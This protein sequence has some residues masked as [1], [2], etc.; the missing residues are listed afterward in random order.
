MHVALAPSRSSG[1]TRRRRPQR[2]NRAERG[3]PKEARE[4]VGADSA[5]A[6]EPASKD[7]NE[8]TGDE[9]RDLGA[10]RLG[11]AESRELGAHESRDHV[12]KSPEDLL[13]TLP[14]C[15]GE[16]ERMIRLGMREERLG[17][18][19]RLRGLS[20]RRV[21]RFQRSVKPSRS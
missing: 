12:A 1:H 14:A 18:G 16:K 5:R 6:L 20:R 9:V 2:A 21:R 7:S 17:E 8:A 15:H 10:R 11:D 19:E 3:V 4:V 13:P